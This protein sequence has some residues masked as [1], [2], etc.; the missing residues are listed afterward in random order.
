LFIR[1]FFS[2]FFDLSSIIVIGPEG[3]EGH[4]R[5]RLGIYGSVEP[6]RLGISEPLAVKPLARMG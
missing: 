4:R 3:T 5:Q 1:L 2:H 6:L